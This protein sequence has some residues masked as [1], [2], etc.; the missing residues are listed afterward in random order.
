MF[1]PGKKHIQKTI[2]DL[3]YYYPKH[4]VEILHN[5]WAKH[6]LDHIFMNI[7]EERFAVLYSDKMSRPNRPVNVSVGLLILKEVNDLTDDE[8]MGSLYFDYRFQYALGITDFDKERICINTLTNFRA[9]LYEYECKTGQD[10]LADEIAALSEKLADFMNLNKSMA[11][12]DSLLVSSSCKKL[13]RL[14]LVYTVNEKMVKVINKINPDI[15]PDELKLYLTE[16]NRNHVLYHT[17]NKDAGSKLDILF[18]DAARLY[19]IAIASPECRETKEFK[20]LARLL[21]EQV[22]QTDTGEIYPVDGKDLASDCLQ[23]PSDPDATYR[24]KGDAQSVGYAL[25][26]VEVRDKE[27]DVGLILA[28]DYKPNIQSDVEFGKDFVK[29]HPLAEQINTL[30]VD[31]AYYS[32]EMIDEAAKKN[33]TVNF[34]QLTGRK[35]QDDAIGSNEFKID[36]DTNRIIS[37]PAGHDPIASW[38]DSDKATYQAKFSKNDCHSCPLKDQCLS[39]KQKRFYTVRFTDKKLKIDMIRSTMDTEQHKVLSN[40]R[41]GIEGVPSVIR[42]RYGIDKIPVRGYLRSKV[43]VHLKIMAYNFKGL[44]KYLKERDRKADVCHITAHYIFIK[45]LKLIDECLRLSRWYRSWCEN[46]C[47][48]GV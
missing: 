39:K 2:F 27:K 46:I 38:Y 14:E 31:G 21:S 19:N 12:M 17:K 41:A 15:I 42:R 4:I 7:N 8:L 22:I 3:E 1:K 6:F 20:N 18:E 36:P 44:L 28:H 29:D 43:W 13:T 25:N 26:L 30:C 35:I 32:P 9:R 24:K 37:C 47:V 5:S 16:S 34:S 48:I 11:R 23:N 33:I 40:F 10:L 45:V